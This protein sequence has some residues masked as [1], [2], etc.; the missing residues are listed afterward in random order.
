MVRLS[1]VFTGEAVYADE[2]WPARLRT[3]TPSQAPPIAHH[4][5]AGA[6]HEHGASTYQ[7]GP[8]HTASARLC[9]DRE[10]QPGVVRLKPKRVSSREKVR[11]PRWQLADEQC[12]SITRTPARVGS[13]VWATGVHRPMAH[14]SEQQRRPRDDGADA[15]GAACRVVGPCRVRSPHARE[16]P[17]Y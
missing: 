10:E 13:T 9:P 16:R 2:C 15:R 4:E 12:A 7:S 1:V 17:G 11:T 14:R 3:C 8:E 5:A 6:F